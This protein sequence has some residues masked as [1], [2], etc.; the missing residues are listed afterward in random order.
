MSAN[1]LPSDHGKEQDMSAFAVYQTKIRVFCFFFS[2]FLKY[3][4]EN[5]DN[6][7][8]LLLLL[9]RNLSYEI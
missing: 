1:A 6:Q 8:L 5:V 3:I 4:F 2:E 7:K 9:L